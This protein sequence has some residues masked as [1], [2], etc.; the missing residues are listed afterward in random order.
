MITD[1][2][3]KLQ[4]KQGFITYR[5]LQVTSG[6]CKFP[7]F[8][9][10]TQNC[11]NHNFL[12]EQLEMINNLPRFH[13]T[14]LHFEFEPF[15]LNLQKSLT[16]SFSPV[17]LRD[18]KSTA[19]TTAITRRKGMNRQFCTVLQSQNDNTKQKITTAVLQTAGLLMSTDHNVLRI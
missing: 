17:S 6:I 16:L 3:L 7:L 14:W 10:S 1:K 11:P 5:L 15:N 12:V 18:K 19:A 8:L 9:K 2:K 4:G 13:K